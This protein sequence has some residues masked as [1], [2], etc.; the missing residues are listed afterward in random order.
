[1]SDKTDLL[2]KGIKLSKE[3]YKLS[4]RYSKSPVKWHLRQEGIEQKKLYHRK[5]IEMLTEL[6]GTKK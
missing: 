2:K 6:Y 5:L 3:G 1:M 4:H